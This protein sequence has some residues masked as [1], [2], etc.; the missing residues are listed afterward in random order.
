MKKIFKTSIL[1]VL[2]ILLLTGCNSNNETPEELEDEDKGIEAVEEGKELEGHSLFIYC[3][4]GMKEP[5]EEISKEFE[6]ATGCDMQVTY[7]NAAQIHTQIKTAEE[8]DAFIAGSEVEVKP[9]EDYV[10]SYK[11][12]V[13]HIPVLAVASGNPKEIKGPEDL[14]K[15]DIKFIMGDPQATPIGKIAEK[16]MSDFNLKDKINI[17]A[18]TATAPAMVTALEAGEADVALVWKENV[19]SDKLEIVESEKM[20][21]YIKKI[22]A[23]ML[24]TTLAEEAQDLFNDYLDSSKVKDIWIE[25][26][27]KIVE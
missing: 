27:Y 9:V 22:R 26:G 13:E 20:D 4:A 5:F 3:G 10:K 7:G 25:Y 18:N 19:K 15:E 21:A 2:M 14:E 8:G 17:V 6:E 12:L 24:T 11:D 16:L 23:V 1:M